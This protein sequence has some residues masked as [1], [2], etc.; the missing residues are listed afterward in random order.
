MAKFD[1]TTWGARGT[2]PALGRT[3]D[4]FGGETACVEVDLG[5]RTIVLDGGS[6]IVALGQALMTRPARPIDI[7]VSHLHLDHVMGLPFF[8][9]LFSPDHTVGLWFAGTE[10]APDGQAL[11][12]TVF[13]PPLLPFTPDAFRCDLV[14]N[15]LP[16]SGTVTLGKDCKIT[17][18]PLHHPGGNTGIR[19]DG[20]KRG[21]A[22]C[23]DFEPDGGT[24]DRDLIDLISGCD[25]AFLDATY[26]PEEYPH[27][28]GFGHADWMQCCTFA[29]EAGVRRLGLF[30]H[31]PDRTDAELR[32]IARAAAR[33]TPSFAVRQGETLDLLAES[34]H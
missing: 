9:P 11:L 8:A 29:R 22:Y 15:A 4:H 21:L 25:L 17:T 20:A 16:T 32:K 13:R 10:G 23:C 19:I 34:A 3:F 5:T 1:V 31:A 14:L 26:L 30:H 6:G 2:R 27:H 24:R 7:V 12:D 33:V 28:I 18:A